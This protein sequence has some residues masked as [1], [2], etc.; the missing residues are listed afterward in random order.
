MPMGSIFLLIFLIILAASAT[1][2]V[3]ER[4]RLVVHRLGRFFGLKGPGRPEIAECGLWIA[5]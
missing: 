3:S 5:E 4:Q 1:K 2:V